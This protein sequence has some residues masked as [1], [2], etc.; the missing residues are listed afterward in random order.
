MTDEEEKLLTLRL[1]TGR[2]AKD[3]IRR[4]ADCL[5]KLTDGKVKRVGVALAPT[6]YPIS[7][8]DNPDVNQSLHAA[9]SLNG[10]D[11]IGGEFL[12]CVQQILERRLDDAKQ[13]LEQ[14]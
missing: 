9:C 8:S 14:A 10:E 11:G 13:Q 3:R 6:T 5:Q 2:L 4:L 7:Y 1:E 12:Q